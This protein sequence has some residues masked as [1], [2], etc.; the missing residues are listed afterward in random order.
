[1]TDYAIRTHDIG[2]AYDSH[3]IL[4]G[5]SLEL[6]RGS[7][8]GLLGCNGSGKTTLIK[9]L[10]GIFE[11]SAGRCEVLGL[12]PARDPVAVRASLGYV[13]QVSDFDTRMT[14]NETLRFL[15]SFYPETWRDE[16][17]EEYLTRF[18]VP[19]RT[20]VG[21]L[22]VG[23]KAR[24]ALV[25]VMACDTELLILDEPTAGLDPVVRRDFVE[26]IIEYMM[27]KQ[28]AVLLSSHQLNEVERLADHVGIVEQGRLLVQSSVE[29]LKQS[30][31]RVSAYFPQA[32]DLSG[33]AGV[34]S[35]RQ[36]YERWHFAAWAHSQEER[37]A[38]LQTL[39]EQKATELTA[40]ESSLESIFVDLVQRHPDV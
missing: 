30:L 6:P 22:S 39:R 15:R 27:E 10:L 34:V 7:V 33:L 9:L 38:L 37:D 1:M 11:P 20:R 21:K 28:R 26:A 40:S 32:P 24:L 2:F 12:D 16:A 36:I 8:Y 29:S 19:N 14:V 5:L 3:P 31:V 17:A 4:N 13:P 35:C 23:Q 25:T 18:E